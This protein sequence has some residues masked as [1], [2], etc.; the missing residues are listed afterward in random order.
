MDDGNMMDWLYMCLWIQFKGFF[1]ACRV[2]ATADLLNPFL[3]FPTQQSPQ[4]QQKLFA[5][6]FTNPLHIPLS[7][8]YNLSRLSPVL[9]KFSMLCSEL[10]SF[11]FSKT[12][13]SNAAHHLVSDVSAAFYQLWVQ[14]LRST[15]QCVTWASSE[16]TSTTPASSL[17]TTLASPPLYGLSYLLYVLSMLPW[18]YK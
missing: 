16:D 5:F 14:L 7:S 18:W 2:P 9:L 12:W 1:S 6:P 11:I 3:E 4:S 8:L 10:P 13:N 15:N 17:S